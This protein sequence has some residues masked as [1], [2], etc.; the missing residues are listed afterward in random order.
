MNTIHKFAK[1]FV[2]VNLGATIVNLNI[3]HGSTLYWIQFG[4]AILT[5]ASVYVSKDPET[6][7]TNQSA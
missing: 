4:L 1:W 6:L 2:H 7:E 3:A 5:S